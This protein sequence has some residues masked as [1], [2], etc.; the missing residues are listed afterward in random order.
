LRIKIPPRKADFSPAARKFSML[1]NSLGLLTEED[2]ARASPRKRFNL[3]KN[4]PISAA[5]EYCG[6]SGNSWEALQPGRT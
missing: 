6:V 2:L 5:T 1:I 3:S 4:G